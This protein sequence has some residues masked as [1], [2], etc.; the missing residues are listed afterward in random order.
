MP[1]RSARGDVV[2]QALNNLL[3]VRAWACAQPSIC[4]EPVAG[5]SAGAVRRGDARATSASMSGS[6]ADAP[7]RSRRPGRAGS[8]L[9]AADEHRLDVVVRDHARQRRPQAARSRARSR[10]APPAAGGCASQASPRRRP[11][12][13]VAPAAAGHGPASREVA[14]IASLGVRAAQRRLH[15]IER[16]PASSVVPAPPRRSPPRCGSP[17]RAACGSTPAGR[18]GPGRRRG[19]LE[20]RRTACGPAAGSRASASSRARVSTWPSEHRVE[21][22]QRQP[23]GGRG[24]DR[25]RRRW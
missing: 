20:A 23:V 21:L 5:M 6:S 16:R 19:R 25:G 24:L 8:S 14:R 11:A 2:G 3:V 7:S 18:P 22:G 12:R 4:G 15:G 13:R 1:S 9:S 17:S 10:R